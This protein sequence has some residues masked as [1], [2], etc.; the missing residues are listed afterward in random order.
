MSTV[1]DDSSG[2]WLVHPSGNDQ[3]PPYTEMPES[4]EAPEP[5]E[6]VYEILEFLP[7]ELIQ[8]V[9]LHVSTIKDLHSLALVNKL[10]NKIF[11]EVAE[12]RIYKDILIRTGGQAEKL[13][14]AVMSRPAR[15][16]L[17]RNLQ[18]ACQYRHFDGLPELAKVVPMM[19]KLEDLVVETPDCNSVD[20]VDRLPWV[21]QQLEYNRLF[22]KA[23]QPSSN[24][25]PKLRSCTLHFVDRDSS[26]YHLGPYSIIFLHPVLTHLTIS[27]AN[28]DPPA[29]LHPKLQGDNLINTTPLNTL[30]LIECDI[31]PSGLYHLLRLPRRLT[32]LAL[33]EA[34]HY[35][36]YIHDHYY[37]GLTSPRALH[38]IATF[39]PQL[40]HL[41]VARTRS[42][43]GYL[44]SVPPLDLNP[45]PNLQSIEFSHVQNPRATTL[46]AP[47]WCDLV[48]RAG[49]QMNTGNLDTT[50]MLTYSE[51]PRQW[52][53]NMIQFFKC[54]FR[55]KSS[56]GIGSLKTLKLIL[57]DDELLLGMRDMA[58]RL[59]A[60]EQQIRKDK[61]ARVRRLVRELG[62]LGKEKNVGVRVVVEWV[63]PNGKTI[64]PYLVGEDVPEV[65]GEYDSAECEG[66]GYG[67]CLRSRDLAI[68]G[69]N[70]GQT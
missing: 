14:Y 35:A 60:T 7:Y 70:L 65:R 66:E 33:T 4:P 10:F 6:A 44:L 1:S 20:P 32:S 19:T 11:H 22:V 49:P 28:I 16:T 23:A 64:P 17:I 56:H 12:P 30:N 62:H 29:H 51:V 27:C 50:T 37:S 59:R 31:D 58:R 57:I 61:V 2:E 47:S 53:E 42:N 55:N 52:W 36:R 18:N 5:S 15:A 68:P 45:F 3:A 13:A 54:A 25:L 69:S 48:H 39:Q 43:I 8:L 40:Q 26:L 67:C 34:N 63:R 21:A 46:E 38:P 9:V 24:I 41:R